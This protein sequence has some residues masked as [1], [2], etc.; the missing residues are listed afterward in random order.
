MGGGRKRSP[1]HSSYR[2]WTTSEFC[3][4]RTVDNLHALC[5]S[6]MLD[7]STTRRPFRLGSCVLGYQEKGLQCRSDNLNLCHD[8]TIEKRELG[9]HESRTPT[10][11]RAHHDLSFFSYLFWLLNI[12]FVLLLFNSFSAPH[13]SSQGIRGAGQENSAKPRQAP[14]S[15]FAHTDCDHDA[16]YNQ[17]A[18]PCCKSCNERQLEQR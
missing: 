3:F 17:T 4:V 2:H 1:R 16:S 18:S 10:V 6:N 13:L 9:L 11:G 8:G 12:Y 14:L 7:L 5:D 15:S